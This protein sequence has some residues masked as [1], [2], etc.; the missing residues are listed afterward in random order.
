[1]NAKKIIFLLFSF[2]II[3][4]HNTLKSSSAI[5]SDSPL[6]SNINNFEDH[7]KNTLLM[8]AADN[9]LIDLAKILINHQIDIY[10][11]N[12]YGLSALDY[13]N[14][15]Q[16]LQMADLIQG[17]SS[18][19]TIVGFAKYNDGLGRIP[20]GLIDCLGN[21]LKINFIN[22]RNNQNIDKEVKDEVAQIINKKQIIIQSK[23]TLLTDVISTQHM[24]NYNFLPK[25][26]IKIAYTMF[27]TSS[28]PKEWVNIIN[29][30]FDSIVVPD[31]FLIKVYKNCGIKVPIFVL[32]IG[33][34]IEELLKKPAKTKANKIFTFGCT[35]SFDK[36][37]N[38]ILLIKAFHEEFKNNPNVLL[39][40]NGRSYAD[41]KE[42]T[43]AQ[44]YI[45]KNKI[46]NI[47]ISNNSLSQAQY[48]NFISSLDCYMNI[49]KGEGFSITPREA[50]AC[51]IPCIITNNTAQQTICNTNLVRS[52]KCPL[53]EPA[54]YF[55]YGPKNVGFFFDCKI[56][57]I[58]LSLKDVYHN[59]Q[60]YL[61]KAN[62]ARQWVKQ[63]TWSSLKQKYLNLISPKKII[64]GDENL[65]TDE[66]LITDSN[67]LFNKY[68]LIMKEQE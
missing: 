35:S 65:I 45:Q 15:K 33:I 4:A 64:L 9:N 8:F 12:K 49:S 51:G 47:K 25:S 29:D 68:K 61:N 32:P 20:I 46:I 11:K 63:Y 22:T 44:Q 17:S 54:Y 56:N 38:H 52:I 13:A 24:K 21:D 30:Y 57:D 43:E 3:I 18:D 28:I 50:L 23:V 16:Y 14:K 53:I 31:C 39:K 5:S 42:F 26:I 37:K 55:E 59:Y 41:N 58:K 10:K 19:L 40:I 2:V 1:M 27:E 60:A 7:N 36:R 62:K 34:Y 48:N 67:D 6:L 66:Y